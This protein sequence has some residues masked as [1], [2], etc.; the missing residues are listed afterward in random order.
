MLFLPI[1]FN[2]MKQ[3]LNGRDTLF[4]TIFVFLITGLLGLLVINIHV[5]DPFKK[6]FVDFEL[7]DIYYSKIRSE[8]SFA[9]TNIVII[10]IGLL[11][12]DSIALMLNRVNSFNPKVVGL[13]GIF[14]NRKDNVPDSLL[15]AAF[16]A[17]QNLVLAG[18]LNREEKGKDI[19][20]GLNTWFGNYATGFANFTGNEDNTSTIREFRPFFI[21]GDVS[22]SSFAAEIVKGTNPKAWEKLKNRGNDYE[23]IHYSGGANSFICIDVENFFD[24]DTKLDILKDKIVLMGYMGETINE[25]L[26][27]EDLHFTPMNP[28]VSGRAIPDMRGVVI[29]ANIISMVLRDDFIHQSPSIIDW[30]FAFVICYLHLALF[31]FLYLKRHKWYHF[32]AK[33][34]QFITSVILIWL[35]F[36]LYEHFAIKITVVPSIVVI[37]LSMDLLYFYEGMATFLNL[38]F[39][40]NTIFKADHPID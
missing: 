33:W 16:A 11:K 23:Y 37:M 34:L 1:I 22:Y 32:A 7:T 28:K 29:H 18:N 9:D 4:S 24:P 40:F 15:K 20:T 19:V 35:A 2:T 13:D 10:N 3:Y 12:R 27:L 14:A 25:S 36:M 26:D 30:L 6:S 31:M 5:F 38:K 8:N 21:E 39:G 17:T